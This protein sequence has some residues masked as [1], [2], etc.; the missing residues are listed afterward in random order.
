MGAVV[1][2]H[3]GGRG[4]GAALRTGLMVARGMEPSAVVYLDGDGEYDAREARRLLEPI[5]RG[6]ADY[7][8]GLRRD[9]GAAGMAW[10]RRVANRAF[11]LALSML[12]GRWISDGQSGFRAFSP[13]AAD[14]AEIIHDYNYAQVLT[15]DLMKKGMRMAEIPISYRRRTTGSSFVRAEYLWRVPLGM[16]REVLNG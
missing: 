12:A 16:A 1:V 13:R 7:V 6:D 10:S 4:L 14:V 5:W 11:S 9:A 15:L 2:S 3:G 8:V